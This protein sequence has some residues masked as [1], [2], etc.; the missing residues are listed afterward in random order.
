[1]MLKGKTSGRYIKEAWLIFAMLLLLYLLFPRQCLAAERIVNSKEELAEAIGNA[2]DGDTILVG[3]IEFDPMPFGIFSLEKSLS[4]KSGSDAPA[5]FKNCT[6][7][8]L[9]GSTESSRIKVRF[10]NISFEGRLSGQLPSSQDPPA[11]QDPFSLQ[12]AV[13][14]AK[15]V[16]AEFKDCSFDGYHYQNGGAVYAI[17]SNSE[18]KPL[19][20]DLSF[21]NCQ[22]K[23]NAAKRGGAIYISSSNKNVHL[24]L[25]GCCFAGNGAS[26]GASVYTDEAVLKAEKCSFSG[27][28]LLSYEGTPQLGGAVCSEYG[29]CELAECV[30][31]ENES[32]SGG[33]AALIS[34]AAKLD[35]CLFRENRGE[36]E[37]GALFI[38]TIGFRA[39]SILN[40]SFVSN[41]APSDPAFS[42]RKGDIDSGAET[43]A[44]F[45]FCSFTGNDGEQLPSDT[46][47]WDCLACAFDAPAGSE[48]LPSEDN[49]W[50]YKGSLKETESGH[51][52]PLNSS[53]TVPDAA[54]AQV[55]ENRLGRFCPG[56]NYMES[57]PLELRRTGRAYLAP[58]VNLIQPRLEYRHAIIDETSAPRRFGLSFAGWS[59]EDGREIR[60]EALYTGAAALPI[61]L[62]ANWK[63][64]A[65]TK[66]VICAFIGILGLFLLLLFAQRR[67]K[68]E[69]KNSPMARDFSRPA[70]DDAFSAEEGLSYEGLK[71]I[72]S[73]RE[74]EVL[75]LYAAGKSRTD[76]A[77][78]LCISES[79]VKTHINSIYSK[80][81]VKNRTELILRLQNHNKEA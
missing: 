28:R 34:C 59:F 16:D 31:A 35:G 74:L 8:V 48:E 62:E 5:V 37:G 41:H 55:F 80:L 2:A 13:F 3:D 14:L 56:C 22:F 30:F 77:K 71:E 10:E 67:R 53:V 63:L 54:A 27:G 11:M 49:D 46:G 43:K 29:E 72:L 26:S 1:M 47:Y 78:E 42:A 70:E 25:K 50:C 73:P 32:A 76:T 65:F 18:N 61:V 12:V 36:K 66:A 64:S 20:L 21:E 69:G 4:I 68:I 19:S 75:Q 39:V 51:Y 15:N 60:E 33:A 58:N 24:S 79:T 81:G 38:E 9:G 17:Y 7:S 23:N 57:Y 40:C 52:I 6:I 45:S 44:S